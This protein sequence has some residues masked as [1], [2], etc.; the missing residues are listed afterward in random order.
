MPKLL[1]YIKETGL[2]HE[3]VM[4]LIEE[5]LSA[6]PELMTSEEK[7]ALAKKKAEEAA[8][9]EKEN[10]KPESQETPEDNEKDKDEQDV[11]PE[12]ETVKLD[13]KEITDTIKKT[14]AAEIKEQLKVQRPDPPK[15]QEKKG[16]YAEP[17]IQKNKFEVLV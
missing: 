11:K 16:R 4:G 3:K 17:K 15:G 7:E 8:E 13:L 12:Q 9:K 6:K 1:D 5:H 14:V 2:S 10:D